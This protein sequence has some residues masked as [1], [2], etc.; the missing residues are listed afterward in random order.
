LIAEKKTNRRPCTS[1]QRLL[2][3]NIDCTHKYQVYKHNYRQLGSDGDR[4]LNR[5]E[6]ANFDSVQ[7]WNS[8]IVAQK[9]VKVKTIHVW[10]K[11]QQCNTDRM[12]C[13][14]PCIASIFNYYLH[15]NRRKCLAQ[16]LR[17]I[18]MLLKFSQ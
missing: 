7:T 18:F 4:T 16:T 8:G 11:N 13:K 2:L 17:P 9:S 15:S 3:M 10:T 5:W 14:V 12:Q 1:R 6:I